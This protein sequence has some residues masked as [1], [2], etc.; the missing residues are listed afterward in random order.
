MG[1]KEELA[2]EIFVGFFVGGGLFILIAIIAACM[3][4]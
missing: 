1:E 3:S 2:W 4:E